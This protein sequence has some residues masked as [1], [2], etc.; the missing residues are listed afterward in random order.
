MRVIILTIFLFFSLSLFSQKEIIIQPGYDFVSDTFLGGE[1]K[2]ISFEYDKYLKYQSDLQIFIVKVEDNIILHYIKIEFF[3]SG[4]LSF[5]FDLDK[6][7]DY[8]LAFTYNSTVT[9]E[10]NTLF[11]KKIKFSKK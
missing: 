4:E 7:S 3:K 11:I 1:V 8:F 5:S 10:Y 9:S 6:D 2:T